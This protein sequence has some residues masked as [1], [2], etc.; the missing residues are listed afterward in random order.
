MNG[1]LTP[2]PGG[3]APPA[4]PA[5]YGAQRTPPMQAAGRGGVVFVIIGLSAVIALL[6][7]I[8]LWLSLRG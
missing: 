7:L 8:V 2:E 6:I 3:F 4:H 5:A 1:G